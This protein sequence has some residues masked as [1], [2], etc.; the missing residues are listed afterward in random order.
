MEILRLPESTSIQAK[1]SV[2]T[3]NAIY[4]AQ[5]ND[6]ITGA[7][8]SASAVSNV[9]KFVT[10]TL[11]NYYL[12]Y[13]GNLE[14]DIYQN[15]G[16]VYSTGLDIIRP[17]CDI[18]SVKNKLAITTDQAI[19]YE[20]VARAII[21]SQTGTFHFI[22]KNKEIIGMGMD[23]LPIN[24][25]IEKLYTMYENGE[26]IHDYSN[27]DL[28]LYKISVDKTSIVLAQTID[29][30]LE[31][32]KVWR[33][34]YYDLSFASGYDYLVDGDF[35]YKV[36]PGDI[37]KACE[38]LV[39]DIAGGNMQYIN[40]YVESFDNME[41]KIQFSKTFING[42][43]NFTVDNILAKYKNKIIPGVI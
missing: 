39:Q 18:T 6:L 11:N 15:N 3:A 5:Y 2:P 24:E 13:C 14:F 30:K 20:S 27:P 19:Q 25:N 36:I 21:E 32:Q 7:N 37:Q 29:N 22:R 42:T 1:F 38:L 9:N 31:Y 10:F 28:N 4:T 17:Y 35:G 40:R 23:Y 43:G 41:F 26:L 34:R 16:L 33:D 8:Y 12:T